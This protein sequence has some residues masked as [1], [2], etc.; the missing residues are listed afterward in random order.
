[1]KK[2]NIAKV[3]T[4]VIATI[5]F[6]A[7][8]AFAQHLLPI[9]GAKDPVNIQ[10][11]LPVRGG[12]VHFL[13]DG[14]TDWK[15]TGTDWNTGTNWT[16]VTGSAPPAAGDVAYFKTA[17][18]T[19]PNLSA[20]ASIAG[21]YFN[22]TASSG[23]D[24][25]ASA[26]QSFTLTGQSTSGSSG[27]SNSSAAA[28]RSDATSS[29]NTIDAP[30]I[31]A[32]STGTS[33]FFNAAGG[34]LVINGAISGSVNLSLKNGTIQLNGNNSQSTTSIDAASTTLVI[35]NNGALGTGTFTINN[36]S[37]LQAGGGA[38][39]LAN[40][41]VFGGNTT[42]SGS[43]GFTFNGTVTSSGS[44]SRTL[45]VSNTGGA[46]FGGTVNLEESGAPAGRI[47]TINGTSPVTINGVVQDGSAQPAALKYTG[48]STLTLN[49]ANTYSGGT[50][51]TIAGST[52]VLGPSGKLGTGNVSLTA[53]N[54]TLTLTGNMQIASSATLSAVNTDIINLNY[55]GTDTILG[56]VV[57]GVQQAAG[58]YGQGFND[59]ESL[60]LEEGTLTV[61]VPEPATIGMLFLGAGLLVGLQRFRRKLG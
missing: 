5:A 38:R 14:E 17:E 21:I 37:T 4:V 18:M 24:I 7:S 31:L 33:T 40:N 51:E 50:Q 52:I 26:G 48:S 35:G 45:T 61:L 49:G 55:G 46:I 2:G 25:T 60:F 28:I 39:T 22:G 36:T 42:L 16:A 47:F 32:S 6:V 43:N 29:A 8:S 15:N 20:S 41:V 27:T 13:P 44:S 23:Y 1:M 59:P 19:N 57:D 10:P 11:V 9:S 53:G 30:L 56:L 12:L 58:I 54:V 3:Q 34:T